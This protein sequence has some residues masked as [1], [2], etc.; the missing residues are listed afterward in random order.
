MQV[1]GRNKSKDQN[2]RNKQQEGSEVI[3]FPKVRLEIEE[4]IIFPKVR[5]E[6]ELRKRAT[7]HVYLGKHKDALGHSS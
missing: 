7:D 3:I 4:V 5:L 2:E 1:Q 6:I